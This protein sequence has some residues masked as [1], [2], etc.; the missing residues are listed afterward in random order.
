MKKELTEKQRIKKLEQ[1]V[2]NQ[3]KLLNEIAKTQDMIIDVMTKDHEALVEYVDSLM[4]E[5]VK[6]DVLNQAKVDKWDIRYKNRMDKIL[7]MSK[8]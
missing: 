5:L 8:R 6:S 3:G 7:K 1:T 4:D 2:E